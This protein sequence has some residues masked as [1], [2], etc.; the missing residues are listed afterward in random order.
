MVVKTGHQLIIMKLESTYAIGER[1]TIAIQGKSIE[2]HIRA[3]TFT[4]S[5]VRYSVR[6]LGDETTLHNIDSAFIFSEPD[7]SIIP[8]PEDNY[9]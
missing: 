3:I 2:G 9:S 6:V 7:A 1:V 4:A 5:K 8:M